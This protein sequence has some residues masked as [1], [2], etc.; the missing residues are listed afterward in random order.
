MAK[1]KHS[2]LLRKTRV[3]RRNKKSQVA[4][5]VRADSQGTLPGGVGDAD[6]RKM[7]GPGPPIAAEW[8]GRL[9]SAAEFLRRRGAPDVRIR[10]ADPVPPANHPLPAVSLRPGLLR[11]ARSSAN[12]VHGRAPRP[13]GA[14]DDVD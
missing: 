10:A 13:R 4:W 3:E 9:A 2:R 6:D 12:S 5:R 14:P 11:S 1:K 8:I 7:S